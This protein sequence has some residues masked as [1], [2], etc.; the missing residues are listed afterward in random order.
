M[1]GKTPQL[2]EM[3]LPYPFMKANYLLAVGGLT[4]NPDCNSIG[5]WS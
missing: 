3:L 2:Y 5:S 4:V 1:K